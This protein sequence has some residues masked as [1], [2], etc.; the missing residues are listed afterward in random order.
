MH[1][2]EVKIRFKVK[3]C[4]SACDN[5]RHD[6]PP[7]SGLFSTGCYGVYSGRGQPAGGLPTGDVLVTPGPIGL[8]TITVGS[9]PEGEGGIRSAVETVARKQGFSVKTLL[10]ILVGH[11]KCHLGK[12]WG[13][14][15]LLQPSQHMASLAQGDLTLELEIGLWALF[16]VNLSVRETTLVFLVNLSYQTSIH[17]TLSNFN[18]FISHNKP[19][20]NKTL[21]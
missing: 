18:I 13:F 10:T 20:F 14:T 6:V 9:V 3:V 17:L 11:E 15:F 16:W 21:I 8:G 1:S 4:I 12:G 5:V 2:T 19:G 7:K